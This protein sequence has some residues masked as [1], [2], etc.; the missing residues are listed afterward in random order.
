[1][2]AAT[3]TLDATVKS[4]FKSQKKKKIIGNTIT[5]IFLVGL[6]FLVLIPFFWMISSALKQDNQVFSIPIQWIPDKPQWNNF[7]T[8]WH[9][10]PLLTF[11]KNTI[12]LSVVVTFIQVLTSSFAA[13][14]FSK[15]R[16][17]GRDTL[18]L[19]YIGTI[20]VPWQAYMIPQFIMMRD[21]HL[22]DTLWSLVLLQ[23]FSAF[24]VFLMRQFYMSIPEELSEAARVDGLNE[25]GIY[26]KIILPLSKPALT[27]L[28]VLTFVN[29]WNDYMGPF[30]YLNSTEVKTIQLGLRM[31]VTLYDAQ[32]ALIMAA[33]LI[34]I[35]PITIIFIFA[36][37]YIIEGIATTGMK[38]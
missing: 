30:I 21:V 32:Y 2:E 15:M 36:Q 37:K 33:S 9:Q 1:M 13:Y 24:G 22:T 25:Y 27:T 14:G 19:A 10:I 23:A 3:K 16:F 18:F 7:V 34:S 29:T 11:F 4:S 31:F 35:I 38:G 12:F 28:I 5:Y 26:F 20:A 6:S 17:K 8:I